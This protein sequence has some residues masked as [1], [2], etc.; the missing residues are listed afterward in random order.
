MSTAPAANKKARKWPWIVTA[1]VVLAIVG[2]CSGGSDK[3]KDDAASSSATSTPSST[4]VA[5]AEVSEPEAVEPPAPAGPTPPDGV[6][7]HTEPGSQGEVLFAEFD[8]HDN[9]TK[10]FIRRGAQ[11]E[12]VDILKYANEAYPNVSKVFVQGKF[13]M[14][15]A[16][17]NTSNSMIL[18]AG[19]DRATLDKIN[20]DGI[21]S[22]KIWE[23]RDGGMVHP[24]LQS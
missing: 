4:A 24:D 18:N 10:G 16:Y 7:F 5:A 23:I 20:F 3:S 19:Y 8:I 12:T 11:S 6:N 13:P 17:G 21:D 14:K 22:S 9:L 15:D 2:Q 1:V